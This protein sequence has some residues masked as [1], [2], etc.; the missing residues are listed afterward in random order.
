MSRI[1]KAAVTAGFTYAQYALRIATGLLLVPLT[2]HRIGA[3]PWGLWLASGEILGHAGM[4]ELGVVGVL[5]WMLAEADG[6]GDRAAMRRLVGSG[7]W[8]CTVVG[9][10]YG[11]I[12]LA[13]WSILPS[14]LRLT[15]DDRA[16]LAAPLAFVVLSNAVSYPMRVFRAVLTGLQDARFNGILNIVNSLLEVGITSVLILKG[17]GLFALSLGLALPPLVVLVIGVVR[18]MVVAPDLLR[19]WSRPTL[20]DMRPLFASGFGVWLSSFGW[21]LLA[22]TTATVIT[23][24][25]Y[26]EWVPVYS[27]TARLGMVSTQLSWVL[28]D[29]GLV[30]LA[31]LSGDPDGKGRVRHMVLMM[32]RLHMLLA[33]AA[34]CGYLIVN[35]AFVARWV[36]ANYFGGVSL[37]ALLAVGIVLSSLI[38][39][40]ITTASVLGNRFR[41]GVVTLVYGIVQ[42]VLAL[43]MGYFW[44]VVGIAGAALLAGAAT[45][46]PAGLALLGPA[47]A[48]TG[49][50]LFAE[51]FGR[52]G[53][54]MVVLAAVSTV[55]CFFSRAMGLGP[56]IAVAACVL[57]IYLWQMRPLYLDLPLDARWIEWLVRLEIDAETGFRSSR[58]G[59]GRSRP[60]V[61]MR[62]HIITGEYPPQPGGVSDYTRLV[63]RGLADQGDGV[64]VWAPAV[65][66]S[67]IP[68][69]DDAGVTV[70][71]LPDRFGRQSRRMLSQHL[72]RLPSPQR[73]LV[74]YV[75]H[76]FG[77]RAANVPFCFWLASRRGRDSIWV[78]FH[79]VAFPFD[80]RAPLRLNLLA[81]VNRLMASL[82]GGAATRAFVSIP[83]WRPWVESLTHP[84][85]PVAWLP[86]PSGIPVVD[87]HGTNGRP[88]A[89]RARF[90][91]GR[92]VVGHLGTYGRLM[93]PL[94]EASMPALVA[95]TD[96]AVLLMGRGSDTAARDLIA[97]HPDL[98]G[99]LGASGPLAPAD[100]STHVSA[101]DVMLQPYPDGVSTRRTSTMV[102][103]SHGRAVVTTEGALTE[104]FWKQSSAVELVPVG[105]S[106]GLAGA[107]RNLLLNDPVRT[108]LAARGRS[109]YDARF[110]IRHT[111]ATLRDQ[112]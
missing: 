17:Y 109:V 73:L 108:A 83:A 107:T 39:G 88:G 52:W 43:V 103:L 27:C 95:Q 40:L 18:V 3:R 23:Y 8:I 22:A 57:T 93:K 69:C 75:P 111:I 64:D 100:L 76:A 38:H 1:R 106:A 56:S 11:V 2:L 47:T 5:P 87:V 94:L 112:S 67:E 70:R 54:R 72:D 102:G 62:W 50:Q 68:E 9:V 4:V 65:E 44:G 21:Q 41:V 37:T 98:A 34:M 96:C 53:G 82:V 15:A 14:V 105:D 97:R 92:P 110:D 48:L 12:A 49:R 99:R 46:V 20:A 91:G 51:V 30:G 19:G 80:R 6:R 101:C 81:A 45:A 59:R 35:P 104:P 61:S 63:A 89:I 66:A 33:G 84:G 60:R 74:Q 71:R 16:M 79:E 28:P 31:Q 32:L 13:V 90:G 42:T 85:T 7:F 78:M 25:G 55:A 10:A 36:G 58:G 86:V 26:P 24:L 29:S 77:W